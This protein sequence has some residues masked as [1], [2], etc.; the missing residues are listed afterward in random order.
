MW[1]DTLEIA[2]RAHLL[3][4]FVWSAVSILAGTAL[5]AWL[6]AGRRRSELLRH[7][8]I[9]TASWGLVEALMAAWFWLHVTPRDLASATRLDRILWLNIGLDVGYVLV[10]I[11][12]VIAAL[13]LGRRF[14]LLGAGM[15]VVVQG[16]ALALLDLALAAQ[17]SR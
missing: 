5:V 4:M 11:S 2:E 13:R 14:G 1:A 8:A 15:G 10:G 3:R 17:I 7:F 16:C 12:L 6:H 9:Q